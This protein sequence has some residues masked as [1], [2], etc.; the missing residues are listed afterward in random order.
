MLG[1]YPPDRENTVGARWNPKDV[2]AIYVSESAD[3]AIAEVNYRLSLQSRPVKKDLR[4]TLFEIGLSVG[5]LVDLTELLDK[6]DRVGIKREHLLGADVTSA[7]MI[8]RTA[9]WL[10]RDALRGDLQD[11]AFGTVARPLIPAAT[12]SSDRAE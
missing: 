11:R 5:A 4:R 2:P 6:L 7:Q 12:P 10:D 8:G 3:T 1:D 9:T